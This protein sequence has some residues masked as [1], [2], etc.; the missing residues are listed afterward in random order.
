VNRK[1]VKG[2]LLRLAAGGLL[3]LFLGIIYQPLVEKLSAA[4]QHNQI[5]GLIYYPINDRERISIDAGPN[6]RISVLVPSRLWWKVNSFAQGEK[7]DAIYGNVSIPGYPYCSYFQLV[8][9]AG[10]RQN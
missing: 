7:V 9:I 4:K 3:A 10:I 8:S 5:S 1:W 6:K 2:S